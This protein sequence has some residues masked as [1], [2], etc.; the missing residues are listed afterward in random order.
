MLRAA[1]GLNVSLGMGGR[2]Q[3]VTSSL[4]V[5]AHA[6]ANNRQSLGVWPLVTA[7][8]TTQA[9]GSSFFLFVCLP[10]GTAVAT[11]SDSKG[12]TW[13]Q[14]GTTQ[15]Y[16]SGG[17][18]WTV[19]SAL[20]GTGGSGHT[21]SLQSVPPSSSTGGPEGVIFAVEV[22]G[23]HSVDAFSLGTS[24]ANPIV[25]TPVTTS[26]PSEILL[27]FAM[28]D[29]FGPG[30]TYTP[31]SPFSILDQQQN[32]G[33]SMAGATAWRV[34]GA[35]GSYGGNCGSSMDNVGGQSAIALVAVGT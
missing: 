13:T 19:W 9:S 30:D 23:G 15:T 4:S 29:S 25:A 35:S 18:T 28:A 6:V 26:H 31:S 34:T 17:G 10:G 16:A 32:G 3:V 12:N 21:F 33:D 27:M 24:T 8:V 5:G 22:I 20:S 2:A 1:S 7:G 14:V 11:V